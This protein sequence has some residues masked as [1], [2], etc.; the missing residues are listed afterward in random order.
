MHRKIT[1][2]AALAL[3]ACSASE[4]DARQY[5]TT[6]GITVTSLKK[7]G[8]AFQFTG[9]K[10]NQICTGTVTIKKGLGSSSRSHFEQCKRDTSACK[11]G[12]VVACN[13]IADE[14]YSQDAKLFPSVAAELYRVACADKDGHACDRA[15]EF[16]AI[17]KHWDKVRQY[18]GKGCDLGNGDAC[19][20]LGFTE[21][22]G[23]GTD[24]N[25]PRA[26]EL[27]KQACDKGSMRGCRAA[28]GLL[29][30]GKPSDPAAAL[31]LANKACIAKYQDGCFVYA[32]A[33]FKG[34]K[35]YA[36][37]LPHLDAACNDEK[38]K[39]RG[40]ACNIAG[41][42]NFDGLG[43]KKDRTRG[44]AY[45]EKSCAQDFADGCSNAGR[46]YK[47]GVGVPRDPDKAAEL[48]AKACKLGSKD[49][50][51]K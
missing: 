10:G 6:E 14:L 11:P 34:K 4:G 23:Q 37:A 13:K 28:A 25:E 26:L 40:M 5:L 30:D 50:C 33:L 51:A 12:A 46:F 48:L 36:L 32:M 27:M 3:C 47:K 16:E 24:K 49:D 29:L 17:D 41:A 2:V 9:R 22:Q 38:Q 18:A 45:F 15:G 20:R 8:N 39:N 42:I 43:M 44:M 21:L 35:D 31:P 7:T 1:L 19:A